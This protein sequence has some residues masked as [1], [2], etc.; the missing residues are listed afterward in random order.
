M[1]SAEEG[2]SLSR[3]TV[4]GLN[5]YTMANVGGAGLER[6]Q[7]LHDVAHM[8][9]QAI[10]YEHGEE[11]HVQVRGFAGVKILCVLNQVL[12]SGGKPSFLLLC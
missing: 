12:L 5:D 8:A 6:F 1:L 11:H 3:S 2:Q 9:T 10:Y 7:L 4:D